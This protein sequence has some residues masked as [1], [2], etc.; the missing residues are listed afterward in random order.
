[1]SFFRDTS[2]KIREVA[3][4]ARYAL[5]TAQPSEDHAVGYGEFMTRGGS[6]RPLRCTPR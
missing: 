6:N 2:P 3:H 1:M 5:H 4:D